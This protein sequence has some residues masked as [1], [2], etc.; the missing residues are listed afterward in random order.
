MKAEFKNRSSTSN[1]MKWKKDIHTLK[2]FIFVYNI[3]SFEM[4][5]SFE[6][7]CHA[8]CHDKF[9]FTHPLTEIVRLE[10]CVTK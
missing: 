2:L 5:F 10:F 3:F 1:V 6:R 8:K 4:G 7:F 9:I